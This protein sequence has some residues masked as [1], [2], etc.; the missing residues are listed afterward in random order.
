MCVSVRV[1]HA[2]RQRKHKMCRS[3]D[4]RTNKCIDERQQVR[5]SANEFSSLVLSHTHIHDT[6]S[7]IHSRPPKIFILPIYYYTKMEENISLPRGNLKIL[8]THTHT[9][10]INKTEKKLKSLAILFFILFFFRLL[11][12]FSVSFSRF[13]LA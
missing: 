7:L 5:A 1:R 4:E 10:T 13:F 9:F 11:I 6:H 8:H 2:A 12:A 3:F